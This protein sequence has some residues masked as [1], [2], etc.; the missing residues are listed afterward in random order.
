MLNAFSEW[1]RTTFP[2]N[3]VV[4]LATPLVATGV[5][6]FA[7]WV[8]DLV[9]ADLDRGAL[10]AFLISVVAGVVSMAYKWLEGH[11]LFEA[12]EAGDVDAVIT[13]SLAAGPAPDEDD[14]REAFPEE[15]PEGTVGGKAGEA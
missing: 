5:A 3:R 9:G 10:A 11:Q 6:A 14:L 15:R 8:Q 12:R 7:N 1:L 4:A 2:V 13:H